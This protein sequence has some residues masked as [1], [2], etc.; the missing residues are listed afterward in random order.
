MGHDFAAKVA[1]RIFGQPIVMNVF[2]GTLVEE[3]V[4]EALSNDWAMCSADYAP[5]DLQHRSH[6]LRI[7]VKQSAARQSWGTITARPSFRIAFKKGRYE[8]GTTYIEERSRNADVFIF[9]WH[10]IT[11]E[12]ADH[13]NSSQWQFYVIA[14]AELPQTQTISLRRLSEIANPVQ[15]TEL[16]ERVAATC[17]GLVL[18]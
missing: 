5:H 4:G 12:T 13:R 9:G 7:Q 14:E 16:S 17:Q 11:D 3:M 10:P 2:R 15:W 1:E 6:G 8:D 18:R